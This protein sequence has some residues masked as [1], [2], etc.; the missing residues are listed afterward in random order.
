[1]L[2]GTEHV[3]STWQCVEYMW[4]AATAYLKT[5][6]MMLAFVMRMPD[7]VLEIVCYAST[8]RIEKIRRCSPSDANIM[9][10]GGIM[11]MPSS[12]LRLLRRVSGK[13]CL[14]L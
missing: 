5:G 7:N 2:N 11:R 1:M 6:I 14:M 9:H 10:S 8:Y 3:I 12:D 4:D 13:R